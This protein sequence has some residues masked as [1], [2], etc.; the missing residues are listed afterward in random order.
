MKKLLLILFAGL[1]FIQG[2]AQ[3]KW[4]LQKCID[5]ALTNNIVIKQ[6]QINTEYKK[7]Q[8]GQSKNDRLPDLNAALSPSFSFGRTLTNDNTYGNFNG[9]STSLTLNSS[10][11]I[12]R[13][14]ALNNIIKQRDFELKSSLEDLQKA[15]DDLTLNIASAY[16]DI[17]FAN[18]LIKAA[19]TQVEQ[20]QKQ[21]DR[22]KDL[23]TAGKLAEGALFE[24]E[25]Q[26]A[27]EE[28]D[29]VNR[30]NNLQIAYL[31]LSQMLELENYSTFRIEI[32]EM[33]EI[34]AQA[35]VTSSEGVFGKA[36]TVRPEIKSADFLLKSY[37]SQLEVAKSAL[38]PSLGAGAGFSD[39]Y[40][41][42]SAGN[43]GSF[44]DQ[45]KQHREYVGLSLNIPIFN[46]FENKNNIENAKL[47]VKNQELQLEGT[48]KEL[49]KQI[50]QAYINAL[51]A[52]KRYNANQVAVKSLE[53]SFRYV[54]EKYSVGRVNSVEYN[55]AKSKLAIAQ[56]DL[57]QAKYEFIFRS[58]I[59]DFYNGIPIQL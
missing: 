20:T 58:K 42:S 11:V 43:M 23:V 19:E 22:T 9:T 5:Y 18:E 41:S 33:P 8:L 36:V 16:L 57:I 6:S 3:E 48:K 47:Q 17:L 55:D 38:L 45:I 39:N 46:K 54:E 15:K 50:E 12:W 40:I 28:L 27:R 49:R 14:G 24:I 52:L 4:S 44:S 34:K 26:Q 25:A 56:S 30:Q 31:N 29:L 35:S 2:Q 21:I 10:I 1:L 53:E 32:P 13:G 59:L 51:A 37:E 7:N